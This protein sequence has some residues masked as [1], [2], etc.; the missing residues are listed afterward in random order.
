MGMEDFRFQWVWGFF[1]FSALTLT[2]VRR[3]W[4]AVVF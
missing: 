2:F 1:A 4:A 3:L